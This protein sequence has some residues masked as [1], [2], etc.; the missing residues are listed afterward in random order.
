M[1][2]PDDVFGPWTPGTG[3]AGTTGGGGT[4]TPDHT[5]PAILDGV[6]FWDSI[7]AYV[8]TIEPGPWSRCK[9]GKHQLPGVVK[10]TGQGPER[11][12]DIKDA[13]A[14]KGAKITVKG[15]SPAAFT[16]TMVIWTPEHLKAWREIRADIKA[17][18][19]SSDPLDI[20]DPVT[21][22]AGVR[23]V[24]LKRPSL[25]ENGPVR[26]SKKITLEVVEWAAEPKSTGSTTPG[27]SKTGSA[28]SKVKDAQNAYLAMGGDPKD[29]E[30][31][32]DYCNYN[33]LPSN[34][35]PPTG[36]PAKGPPPGSSDYY[37]A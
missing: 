12:L 19:G 3:G 21:E 11:K 5:T 26:G 24:I 36:Y 22:D 33:G 23:S 25:I 1:Y 2:P 6:P 28:S 20:A 4:G 16:I 34:T 35:P 18:D 32:E 31:W 37:S 15:W 13:P 27:T 9:L 17:K 7:D 29:K 8:Q 14:K 10:V 30:A